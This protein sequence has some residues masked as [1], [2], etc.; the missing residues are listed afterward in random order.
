[1]TSEARK[2]EGGSGTEKAAGQ[3]TDTVRWGTALS[4]RTDAEAEH[5]DECHAD[6][7]TPTEV[8]GS[9]VDT[10]RGLLIF[11]AA[12]LATGGAPVEVG[13]EGVSH[14]L[15]QAEALGRVV[16]HHLLDQVKQLLVVLVLGQHVVLKGT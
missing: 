5:R 4:E 10:R 13:E 15:L 9:E 6:I 11:G 8:R 2:D 12:T 16:L 3:E 7:Q 1:M 14:G